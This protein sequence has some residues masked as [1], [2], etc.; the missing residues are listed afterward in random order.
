MGDRERIASPRR[1][2]IV[3]LG[4][5]ACVTQGCYVPVASTAL[6]PRTTARF[7]S[8][9]AFPVYQQTEDGFVLACE[10]RS[11]EGTVVAVRGDSVDFASVWIRQPVTGRPA[12]VPGIASRV[13]ASEVRGT[14]DS[15]SRRSEWR[16]LGLAA[17]SISL[18]LIAVVGAALEYGGY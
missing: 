6:A 11:A 7:E 9:E 12:C 3:L 4:V 1:L 5:A 10:A 14:P 15:L 13:V 8:A 2:R 17:V 16:T 18:A